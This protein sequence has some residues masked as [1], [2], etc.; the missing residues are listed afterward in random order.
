MFIVS[1]RQGRRIIAFDMENQD[2]I[3]AVKPPK[4]RCKNC[5]GKLSRAGSFCPHCG[6]RDFDGR[7]K[8]RDL[9]AKFFA[10]LTHLDNKFVKMCWH[11][12]VPARVT[13]NYFQGKIKRYPHPVQFFFIVMFFFLLFLNKRFDNAGFNMTSGEMTIGGSATYEVKKGVRKV[14]ETGFFE[15]LQHVVNARELRSAYDSLPQE[16]QTPQTRL[17]I[18]SVVRNVEGP[19]E[20]ATQLFLNLSNEASEGQIPPSTL[21]TVSLNFVNTSARIASADLVHLSADSIISKYGFQSW[22][23]KVTVRQG[24]KSI[25][26]PQS[27]IHRYVGS[28]GWTILVLIALM[29]GLLFLLYWRSGRYYTEHFIFMMHQQS[30]AFLVLVFAMMINDW[31]HPI[32]WGWLLALGWMP[33][34]MLWAMKLYY[35]EH[36]GWTIAK[37]LF[38]T[39]VYLAGFTA[40]FIATLLLVFV[41]L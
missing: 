8:M 15:A 1:G 24:L 25:K 11:L 22:N 23:E 19:W 26:S 16:W 17:A 7:I 34:S 39:L 41:L 33:V 28:F 3:T 6:Q 36:W 32:D 18:D 10:N 5:N 13:R 12:L 14:A 35:Q 31:V 2:E 9:L 29:S 37:W 40:L 20:A 21:D 27:L 4:A 30:G 38:A